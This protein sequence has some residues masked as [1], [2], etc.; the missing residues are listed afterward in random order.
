MEFVYAVHSVSNEL[1]FSVKLD[2]ITSA[3]RICT[4]AR[5][6]ELAIFTHENQFLSDFQ[7]INTVHCIYKNVYSLENV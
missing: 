7:S 6:Y 1:S 4:W 3:S 5:A 2:L